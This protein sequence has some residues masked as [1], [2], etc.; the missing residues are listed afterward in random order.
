MA[1]DE[2]TSV[3]PWDADAGDG[4]LSQQG[5]EGAT[6]Q[7]DDHLVTMHDDVAGGAEEA[8][9]EGVGSGGGVAA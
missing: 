1:E 5:R 4:G 7:G 6:G 2:P 9:L 3:P 8:L